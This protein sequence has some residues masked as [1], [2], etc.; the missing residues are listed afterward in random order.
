MA[1]G[2][3]TTNAR[4]GITAFLVA[5]GQVQGTLRVGGTFRTT[6]WRASNEGRDAGADGLLVDNATLRI[7][8]AG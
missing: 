6:E 5:T 3:A 7:G 2:T 1:L 8:S 4:T